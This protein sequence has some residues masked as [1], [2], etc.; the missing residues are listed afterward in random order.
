MPIPTPISNTAAPT[1]CNGRSGSPNSGQAR[2]AANT[3]SKSVA[4]PTVLAANQRIDQF[5]AVWPIS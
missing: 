4:K 5:R 2:R 3:G 1:P